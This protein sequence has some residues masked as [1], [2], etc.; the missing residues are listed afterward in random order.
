D[1]S[2]VVALMQAQS[3]RR[4]QTFTIG[5]NEAGYNEAAYARMVASHLGT[6]HTEVFVRPDD[7]LQLIPSLPSIYSEPFADSS[8]IPTFLLSRM[9]RRHVTVALSGD[10]GDEVFGGY[11]R[12]TLARRL[13][14][15]LRYL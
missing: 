15:K 1:S 8:Q 14:G 3:S 13:W 4:V 11:N 5:F 7:A 6:Q 12:Y 9:T 10:A 2:T